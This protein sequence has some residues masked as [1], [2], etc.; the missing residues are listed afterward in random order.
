M[1]KVLVMCVAVVC[2]GSGCAS[3]KMG[4]FEVD[5]FMR[6]TQIGSGRASVGSNGVMEIEF[7]GYKS[8]EIA[9]IEAAVRAA[10]EGALAGVAP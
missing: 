8:D 2:L 4:P 7:D 1:K 9:G 10:V 6:K 5:S 3:Y